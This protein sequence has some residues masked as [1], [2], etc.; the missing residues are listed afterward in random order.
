MII[1]PPCKINIG[2]QVL[3]R[4]KD[5]YHNLSSLFY[6]LPLTDVLEIIS[7]KELSFHP[8]GIPIPGKPEDNL[9]QK[10]WH[11]L[12]ENFA[13][14]PPVAIHLHK[15]IPIG[16]GLG[17]GSSDGANMLL[18]LNR[19]YNLN[20]TPDQ[21]KDY[22]SR[23]GSDCAFFIQDHPCYVTGRGD[24]LFPF[25]LESLH[26]YHFVLVCPDIHIDTGW[27]YSKI[28]PKIPSHSLL[29]LVREPVET[30]KDNVI[31]DFESPVL[32]AYPLL[33]TIRKTLYNQG[34]VYVSMSGSGSSMYGIFKEVP[35]ETLHFEGVSVFSF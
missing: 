23:L 10:A 15:H 9:C 8:T 1:F 24:E 17:G 21:L 26:G 12:K 22:A 6:P 19:K 30:W 35:A 33:A 27:A 5:G 31:N 3:S 29:D 25:T 34:A 11:L 28:M 32:A 2:L 20:L 7:A 13:S 4:R 16:A 14:L 18:L